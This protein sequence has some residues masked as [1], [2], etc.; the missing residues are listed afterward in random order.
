MKRSNSHLFKH[1]IASE[2]Q[3]PS[4]AARVPSIGGKMFRRTSESAGTIH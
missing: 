4:G 2:F 3:V 1:T